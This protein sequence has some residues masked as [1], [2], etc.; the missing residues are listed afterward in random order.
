MKF[1]SKAK[2]KQNL[3]V[4]Y[5]FRANMR[6]FTLNF[7]YLEVLCLYY[8]C[9][10]CCQSWPKPLKSY[11]KSGRNHDITFLCDMHLRCPYVK[12]IIKK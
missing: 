1:I 8:I 12:Q 2:Q 6:I 7:S 10:L 3:K 4:L 11:I 9:L 5:A